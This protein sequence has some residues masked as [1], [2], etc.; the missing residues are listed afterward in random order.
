MG[1]IEER[2]ECQG[3]WKE[4]QPYLCWMTGVEGVGRRTIE[5]LI[6]YAGSPKEVYEMKVSDMIEVISEKK[7]KALV[8][9]KTKNNIF[10][11]YEELHKKGICFYSIYHPRYPKRLKNIPDMPYGIYVEGE[12]PQEDIPSIAIIGA[13]QCSGYGQLMAQVCGRDLAL[14]GMNIVSGMARGIDGISQKAAL[15]AGGKIYAVLGCGTNICYPSENRGIYNGAKEN[16]AI[17]SE[18][19]PGTPP[20]PGLFPRRNRIIS[21][22]AD[23]VLIIEARAKSGTLITAD[24]ALEQGKEVYVLPG[25]V[26]D[27]LS[28]GCNRMLKQGAGLFTSVKELLEES[29]LGIKPEDA[30]KMELDMTGTCFCQEQERGKES[31]LEERVMD[32][33]DFYPKDTDCLM[34]ETQIGYRLLI[35]IL[36]KICLEGKAERIAAN[37]FIKRL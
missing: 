13:R 29:G 8:L 26:T 28:Q 3:S 25:R 34:Q 6:H 4:H 32:A 21:G 7:A 33:L 30:G 14:A 18:Y 12:L 5:K 17:I 27:P 9:A 24:M 20:A 37:Q 31:I 11:K 36:S 2:N 22:L 10:Q 1:N 35:R 16:G 19:P 15:E 23:L